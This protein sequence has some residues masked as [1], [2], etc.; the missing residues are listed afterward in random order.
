DIEHPKKKKS[1][2]RLVD[3]MKHG[4]QKATSRRK[5]IGWLFLIAYFVISALVVYQLS[6]FASLNRLDEKE[7]LNIGKDLI[8]VSS[9]LGEGSLN[10][11]EILDN[12]DNIEFSPYYKQV[13]IRMFFSDYYQGN[14]YAFEEVYP[15]RDSWV[16]TE[17]LILGRMPNNN[18]E[19]VIDEWV[20]EKIIAN[21]SIADLGVVNIEDLIGHSIVT[22]SSYSIA[23]EIVGV[24]QTESPVVVVT[25][26]AIFSFLNDFDYF[27]W[28][29]AE[30]R[31]EILTGRGILADDEFLVESTSFLGLGEELLIGGTTY[32]IVGTYKTIENNGDVEAAYY[33]NNESIV[34]SNNFAEELVISKV[35]EIF[36]LGNYGIY[37]YSDDI[38]QAIN[39]ISDSDEHLEVFN[40]YESQR[41][42]AIE[43]QK[44]EVASRIQSILITLIGIIVY[45]FFMMRSSMLSRIKEIGI[46]RSIGATKR[47]IYK[48]FIGEIFW[49]TTLGSLTGYLSMA[50]LINRVQNML[51]NLISVFYFPIHYFIGG[52]VGIYLINLMFGLLPIFSLLRKTPSEINSKFDI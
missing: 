11:D 20:A 7:F 16:D 52:I 50:F 22:V 4:F 42:Y 25:D 35:D 48:I 40:S 45:I 49:F 3:T 43:R 46:Y 28:G 34:V 38:E 17:D 12:V 2:I 19:I 51:G 13:D 21:K 6:T 33:S 24:I 9:N 31:I 26:E 41:A 27:A 18:L 1:F 36:Y 23:F 29:S 14:A 5:F 47:D 39:D 8:S 15:V 32:T 30:N 37:F 10:I 44:S